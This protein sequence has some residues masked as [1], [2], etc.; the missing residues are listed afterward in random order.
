MKKKKTAQKHTAVAKKKTATKPASKKL[1]ASVS[2]PSSHTHELPVVQVKKDLT[3]ILL[4]AVVAVVAL[5]GMK[6]SG[7]NFEQVQYLFRF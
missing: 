2:K 5:L 3:M 6:Y 1:T 7:F 4:F